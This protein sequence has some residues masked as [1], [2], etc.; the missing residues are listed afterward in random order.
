[1]YQVVAATAQGHI[2]ISQGLYGGADAPIV[3]T[4][5]S[6]TQVATIADGAGLALS[7]N[8]ETLYAA[9][10]DTVTA[11]S[12]TTLKETASYPLHLAWPSRWPCRA[13]GYG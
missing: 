11:F 8:D 10:G 7:A 3:V 4:N 2:F 12:T 5:L 13:A 1:M 9:T 6:G